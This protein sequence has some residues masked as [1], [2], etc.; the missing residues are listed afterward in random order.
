[1]TRSRFPIVIRIILFQLIFLG[2]HFLY[3]WA[4]SGLTAVFSGI[5]ESVFQHLKVGFFA[6][7]LTTLV[8]YLWLRSSLAAPKRFLTARLF[9]CV[10]LPWVMMVYFLLSPLLFGKITRIV[11]EILF[12]N[13]VVLL[14][15]TTAFI[16]E[17]YV[18]LAEPRRDA[19]ALLAV[20]FLITL[21]QYI[22]FTQRL[23]WFDI[24]ARPPGW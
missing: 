2:L 24:F 4:P 15:A 22:V 21:A 5:N 3:D 10:F 23:P 18:E 20:L 6:C 16:I 7:I 17:R 12:A 9:T 14:T 8:E 1:M 13:T 19:T 11:L